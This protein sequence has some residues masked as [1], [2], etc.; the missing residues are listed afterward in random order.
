[1]LL[2]SLPIG[3]E[4]VTMPGGSTGAVLIPGSQAFSDFFQAGRTIR[5]VL[6]S[7]CTRSLITASVYVSP[8]DYDPIQQVVNLS[9]K[10]SYSNI[11]TSPNIPP[12]LWSVLV[13][14][15][16]ETERYD[17]HVSCSVLFTWASYIAYF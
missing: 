9:P 13:S 11:Y 4:E 1:M 3:S 14:T 7:N 2:I 16:F 5:Y 6:E 12:T 15:F 10:Q 17:P 8:D